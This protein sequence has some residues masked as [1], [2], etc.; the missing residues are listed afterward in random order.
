VG[1][2]RAAA[3]WAKA[4]NG[5]CCVISGFQSRAEQEVLDVLLQTNAKIIMVLAKKMFN[6]C[7]AKYQ[8]AVKEGRMLLISPFNN[9]ESMVTKANAQRRNEYLLNRAQKV[10]V[11]YVS[12]M[13]MLD[14]LL[15][16]QAKEYDILV[17]RL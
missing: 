8:K 12:P 11:G 10:V 3:E 16:K 14:S 6:N 13:G 2:N 4:L 9:Y 15:S 7:P 17:G 1:V 5:D